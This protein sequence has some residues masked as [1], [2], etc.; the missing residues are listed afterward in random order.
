MRQF[1]LP[2]DTSGVTQKHDQLNDRLHS[3]Y[4]ETKS[5]MFSC[6]HSLN[7]EDFMNIL[8]E[9]WEEWAQPYNI[10][11][12]GKRVGISSSGLN[13]DW[14]DQSKFERAEAILNPPKTPERA[15]KSPLSIP[16]PPSLRK[17]SASYYKYKYEKCLE[18]TKAPLSLDEVPGLLHYDRIE[19]K[20][21]VNLRITNQHGSMTAKEVLVLVK[22]QR[23][24]REEQEK[25]KQ[26]ARDKRKLQEAA[27]TKC[28]KKCVCGKPDG[29]CEALGLKQCT[30]CGSVL[31]SQC[32]KKKCLV[33]GKKP[34]MTVIIQ[35]QLSEDE[36]SEEDDFDYESWMFE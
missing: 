31:K 10:I 25:R 27:F 3:R 14:M 11:K 18:M 22:E 7:R 23:K 1:I 4:E 29:S 20:R 34:K 15:E 8:G 21:S 16:S 17:G 13:V 26:E 30:S 6:Y 28:K 33:D 19:P 35:E 9:I 36:M 24:E 2:P 32:S 12:A 5:S